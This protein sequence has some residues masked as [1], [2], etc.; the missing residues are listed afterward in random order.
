G[1][2]SLDCTQFLGAHVCSLV[3]LEPEDKEPAVAAVG[4]HQGPRA[5]A[6]AATGKSDAFLD[7]APAQIAIDQ[8]PCHLGDCPA[9]S[10]VGQLRLAHPT[11]EIA[12]LEDAFQTISL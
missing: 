1:C 11:G 12:C 6:L 4:R 7:N 8:S 10:S 5:T 3:L 2:D 9:K